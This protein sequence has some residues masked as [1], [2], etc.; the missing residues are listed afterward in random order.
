ML[1]FIS[2]L[3]I[4]VLKSE[5][6]F[7]NKKNLKVRIFFSIGFFFLIRIGLP[8]SSFLGVRGENSYH[9]RGSPISF[10]TLYLKHRDA[11]VRCDFLKI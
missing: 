2:T 3:L 1:V 8:E 5:K 11:K 7:V 6:V 10:E 9:S 4:R